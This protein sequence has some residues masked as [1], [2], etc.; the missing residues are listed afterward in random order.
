MLWELLNEKGYKYVMIL[1]S[2]NYITARRWYICIEEVFGK[3]FLTCVF[4]LSRNV[5]KNCTKFLFKKIYQ[6]TLSSMN[7][8]HSCLDRAKYTKFDYMKKE[9]R[10]VWLY[11]KRNNFIYFLMNFK[12]IYQIWTVVLSCVIFYIDYSSL[13]LRRFYDIMEININ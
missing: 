3:H 10:K 8:C 9:T 4:L 1:H 11:E 6:E 12:K 5:H 2:C 7:W 13:S